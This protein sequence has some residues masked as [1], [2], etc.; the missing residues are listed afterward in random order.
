MS[1]LQRRYKLELNV[2]GD[3]PGDLEQALNSFA[4][5]WTRFEGRNGA[6]GGP[7]SGWH[8]KLI[9]DPEMTH[10][11]YVAELRRILGKDK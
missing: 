3:T 8:W 9:E 10:E 5:E 7:N 2:Q 1:E 6:M 4:D 11:K